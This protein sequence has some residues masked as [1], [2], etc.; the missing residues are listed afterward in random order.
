MTA[1]LYDTDYYAWTQD[2]AERLRRLIGDNRIDAGDLADEVED[3]GKSKLYAVFGLV[4]RV[5]EHGSGR[6]LV[7]DVEED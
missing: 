2:Q 6:G 1:T 4:E 7:P 3:L 5:L